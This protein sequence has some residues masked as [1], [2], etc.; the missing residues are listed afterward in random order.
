M[1]LLI[2]LHR[3]HPHFQK[4]GRALNGKAE[5][6]EA[7][8][9]AAEKAERKRKNS[10]GKKETARQ[11]LVRDSEW[12]QRGATTLM[13]LFWGGGAFIIWMVASARFLLQGEDPWTFGQVSSRATRAEHRKVREG[14]RGAEE[15]WQCQL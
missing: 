1:P 3:I 9:K 15:S 7:A 10:D 2:S 11:K 8:H 4:V 5:K 6:A 14:A 12:V 13:F